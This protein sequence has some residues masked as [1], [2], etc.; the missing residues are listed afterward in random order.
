MIPID[1]Q[2]SRSK[3]MLGKGGISVSQT[4]IFYDFLIA[5]FLTEKGAKCELA[6]KMQNVIFLKSAQHHKHFKKDLSKIG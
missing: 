4:S 6:E 1:F 3:V 2:V 5:H